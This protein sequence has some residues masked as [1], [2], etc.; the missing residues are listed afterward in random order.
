MPRSSSSSSGSRSPRRCCSLLL[1]QLVSAR[2]SYRTR[3]EDVK[4]HF[5]QFGVVKDVYLPVDYYTRRPRGFGFVEF[6]QE[7][8]ARE[9]LEKTD[10]QVVLGTTLKVVFAR[11]GRK[12]VTF[13][14]PGDMKRR[15]RRYR[16]RRSDS[17]R[18]R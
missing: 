7:S 9:A 13:M 15:E 6:A 10:G 14:Q 2:Q 11:E 5:S 17:Y 3:A 18:R 4:Q 8:D 16:R 12:A 1:R